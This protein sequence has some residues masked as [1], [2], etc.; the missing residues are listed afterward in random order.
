MAPGVFLFDPARQQ[1]LSG[2]N[3]GN[4]IGLPPWKFRID[5][6][7]LDVSVATIALLFQF[8]DLVVC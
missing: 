4:G 5:A 2:D 8:S 3:S 7:L 1:G 6:K